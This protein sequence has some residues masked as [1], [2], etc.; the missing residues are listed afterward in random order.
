M[1]QRVGL[2]SGADELPP[3]DVQRGKE[4]LLNFMVSSRV[5]IFFKVYWT[6]SSTAFSK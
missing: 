5:T 1:P 3:L 4:D 2:G 6:G